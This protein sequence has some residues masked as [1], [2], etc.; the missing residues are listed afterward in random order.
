MRKVLVALAVLFGTVTNVQASTTTIHA[1]PAGSIVGQEVTLT[2][3]FTSSCPG[4]VSSHYFT[5]DGK[6]YSGT[7]SHSGLSGSETVSIS[8]LAVGSHSVRYDWQVKG[9]IC[10]GFAIISYL[11]AP[12][13]SPTPSA[14][15]TPSPSPSPTHAQLP[16]DPRGGSDA[17]LGYLGAGL[18]VVV[19]L[20]G[21]ALAVMGRRDAF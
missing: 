1:T 9:T 5:I 4:I 16:A 12:I 18:I 20:A 11:V 14:A 3:T 21:V 13:P 2:A 6:L 17:L 19:V 15:P 8:T 7:Y 10:R